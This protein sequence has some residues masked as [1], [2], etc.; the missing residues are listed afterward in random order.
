MSFCPEKRAPKFSTCTSEML[1][2]PKTEHDSLSSTLSQKETA[3]QETSTKGILPTATY[4][5]MA[6]GRNTCTKDVLGHIAYVEKVM[7]PT[8]Y[9]RGVG[10]HDMQTPV[11][12]ASS[13]SEERDSLD[14]ICAKN[15]YDL[16]K[17][18]R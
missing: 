9:E 10:E 2:F 15:G 16:R 3:G 4:L 7:D 6:C 13:T 8:I 1:E 18:H 11:S 12:V 5:E 14:S 17:L